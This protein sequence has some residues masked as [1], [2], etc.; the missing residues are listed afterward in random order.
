MKVRN[1]P[2]WAAAPRIISLGLAM[3]DEKSVMAPMPKKIK[4]GYTPEV[5]PKYR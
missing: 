5:T 4:G 2:N 3:S 1:T